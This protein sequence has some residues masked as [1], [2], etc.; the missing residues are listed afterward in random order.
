[1]YEYLLQKIVVF[2]KAWNNKQFQ[3]NSSIDQVKRQILS[4][5]DLYR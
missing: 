2:C 3:D 1:M 4:N 5:Y